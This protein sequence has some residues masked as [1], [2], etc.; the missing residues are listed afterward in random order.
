MQSVSH[1]DVPKHSVA[2]RKKAMNAIGLI[3]T[4]K[5]NLAFALNVH[6]HETRGK[7]MVLKRLMIKSMLVFLFLVQASFA[8]SFTSLDIIERSAS[9]DC[10]D[11]CITGICFWLRCTPV[12]CSIETTPKIEH[13][14]PDLVV[15]SYPNAGDNPWTEAR[16][17][18]G[19]QSKQAV[20][21]LTGSEGTGRNSSRLY[22]GETKG[23]PSTLKFKEVQII[24][25]PTNSLSFGVPYLCPS[26]A[27]PGFPYF[28][29][30]LDALAWRS[31]EVEQFRPESFIPG[32]REITHSP[33]TSWGSVFPRTGYVISPEDPKAAAVTS[34]RA[35]DII[36]QPGQLPHLYT[37]FGF[38][39]FRRFNFGDESARNRED[40]VRSGGRW[41]ENQFV[42]NNGRCISAP[43]VLGL[44]PANERTDN[45]QMI[46][47]KPQNYC[48]AFGSP[49]EWS[50]DKYD[51]E[52]RYAF[53]YWRH[54]ECCVPGPGTFLFS[55]DIPPVCI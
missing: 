15:S 1:V 3:W 35:I 6:R 36:T 28:S 43:S 17:V 42:R 37:T 52:G 46:S 31:P 38:S 53:N 21:S 29:S 25:G 13:N 30:E 2:L 23:G 40:C 49:D 5:K 47:P 44:P 7:T 11:W 39:G 9:R 27:S 16:K 18:Y 32:A 22:R 26:Q 54:Y 55:I 24:G 10:L 50:E 33:L 20:R 41:I 45:W 34:Q 12:G 8:E 51:E 14:L 19:L 4:K 48:E